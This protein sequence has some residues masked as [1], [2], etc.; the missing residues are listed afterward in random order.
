MKK[1]RK[2][3]HFPDDNDVTCDGPV[4]CGRRFVC[5]KDRDVHFRKNHHSTGQSITQPQYNVCYI[6]GSAFH[7]DE[8]LQC[9]LANVHKAVEKTIECPKC[10]KKFASKQNLADHM[11]VHDANAKRDLV[12]PICGKGFLRENNLS[13]HMV[14]HRPPKHRCE[15]CG[16]MF[17]YRAAGLMTHYKQVHKIDGRKFN[18]V[19]VPHDG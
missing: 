18:G 12:C 4:G 2:L 3:I 7:S 8:R 1:H 15:I 13:Q 16:K 14:S 6:C 11:L 17:L 5:E 9:H 19:S 10:P